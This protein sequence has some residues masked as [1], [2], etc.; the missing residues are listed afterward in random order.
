[1]FCT[2]R[3]GREVTVF[4]LTHSMLVSSSATNVRIFDLYYLSVLYIKFDSFPIQVVHLNEEGR[5]N[6]SDRDMSL[7]KKLHWEANTEKL[8]VT[9][10]HR[11]A[12]NNCL[13]W[14]RRGDNGIFL[15]I[16]SIDTVFWLFTVL[17]FRWNRLTESPN[18][19]KY[20]QSLGFYTVFCS[21]AFLFWNFIQ[22][23]FH[24]NFAFEVC[25]KWAQFQNAHANTG[26]NCVNSEHDTRSKEKDTNHTQTHSQAAKETEK[27]ILS[28]FVSLSANNSE[29]SKNGDVF[30]ANR[31]HNSERKSSTEASKASKTYLNVQSYGNYIQYCRL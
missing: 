29:N 4:F 31:T 5:R 18:T 10:S 8:F 24:L 2:H 3:Y 26:P 6:I 23:Y 27:K 20:F 7:S 17:R 22:D 30:N 21:F 11:Y 9:V 16:S 19:L 15:W 13:L 28:V 1:M 25:P 14:P 12:R